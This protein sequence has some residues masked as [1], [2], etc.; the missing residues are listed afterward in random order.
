M[1]TLNGTIAMTGLPAHLG[2]IVDFCFYAVSAADAPAPYD[3]DPPAE[4]ATDCQQ[5]IK[6]VELNAESQHTSRDLAFCAERPAGFYYV[7]VRV[8]L[9]RK[10]GNKVFAQ[11]EQFFF[12]RRPLPMPDEGEILVTFPVTWPALPL[13]QLHHY[14]TISPQRPAPG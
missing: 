9:F 5:V 1:G 10:D 11:V 7:G 3:G 14:G 4:A 6:D 13:E 12:A 8:V 2:M